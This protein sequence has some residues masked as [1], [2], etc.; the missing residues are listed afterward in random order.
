MDRNELAKLDDEMLG[1]WNDHNVDVFLSHCADDVVWNDLGLPEPLRG[2]EAAAEHFGNWMTAF[3]DMTSTA[4]NRVIGDD[5][6]AVELTFRGTNTGPMQMGEDTIPAT[7]KSV[8][9]RGAY[10]ARVRDGRLVELNTY[11]DAISMMGQLGLMG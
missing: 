11:P 4:S 3:P 2:K 10:F 8:A 9:A 7:G 6:V 1:A 5:T